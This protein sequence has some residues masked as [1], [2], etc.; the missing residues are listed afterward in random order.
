PVVALNRAVA[1]G[2]AD[3]ATA[4]LAALA[5]VDPGLPRHTA[6]SAYLHEKA[7]DSPTAARLYAEAA[8]L[9]PNLAE[10]H[11]LTRQAARLSQA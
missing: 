8:L 4:G 5:T 11:H 2:E 9:A 6:A 1:V 3:G 10:R 7:G